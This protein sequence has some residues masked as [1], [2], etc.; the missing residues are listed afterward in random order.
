MCMKN[1]KILLILVGITFVLV[2]FYFIYY[3]KFGW[4]RAGA[5]SITLDS[6]ADWQAGTAAGIDLTTSPGD[7]RLNSANP[8]WTQATAAAGWTGRDGHTSVVFDNKMWVMGGSDG[9]TY[10]NDVWWSTDGATWTQATAAAGWTGRFFHSS[11]VFDNKMWVMGGRDTGGYKNDVW[12]SSDG[13]NWTQAT[14]DAGWSE[15]EG[16]TSVVFDNK[17]W[18]MGGYNVFLSP[19]HK[20][21]VWYSTDGATWTQATAAAGWS[22]R[23]DFPSVVYDSKMWVM[24]GYHTGPYPPGYKNDVWWSTDG[25][26]WTQATAAAGWTWRGGHTSVVYDNKMWVM[27]GQGAFNDVWWSTDGATWTQ[28]TAAG[29]A[30]RYWHTSVVYDNKMWVMGGFGTGPSFKN[31]VWYSTWRGIHTTAATQI[32]GGTS[33]TGWTT[34]VPAA[35]IPANTAISFRFR[36]SLN[37]STWTSWS[38][39]TPYAASIDISGLAVQRYLQV[40]ATLSN[41]DSVS[42][43]TIDSYTINFNNSATPTPTTPTPTP[44]TPTP[45]PPTPT[46]T[47]PTPTP[48]PPTPTPTLTPTSSDTP[49]PITPSPSNTPSLSPSTSL[50][51]SPSPSYSFPPEE[52]EIIIIRIIDHVSKKEFNVSNQRENE[53]VKIFDQRPTFIGIGKANTK[54]DLYIGSNNIHGETTSND[55]GIFTYQPSIDLDFGNHQILASQTLFDGQSHLFQTSNIV[56]FEIVKGNI[57]GGIDV[58]N[59]FVVV[60]TLLNLALLTYLNPFA[61]TSVYFYRLW[62]NILEWLGIRKKRKAWGL[63]YDYLTKKTL[64]LA[65]VRIVD[66]TNNK[67]RDTY[68]TDKDGGY[69]F[70]AESGQFI[71]KAYKNL[72]EFPV[73]QLNKQNDKIW[74]KGESDG[75]Y[76]DL[77]S[78][79][80]FSLG[81]GEEHLINCNIPMENTGRSA[82]FIRGR[83]IADFMIKALE[84]IRIPLLII[85]TALSIFTLVSY[86]DTLAILILIF[87]ILLWLLEFLRMINYYKHYGE[88]IDPEGSL[89]S[90]AVVRLIQIDNKKEKIIKIDITG[91]QG[92]YNLLVLPGE[93]YLDVKKAGYKKYR[94]ERFE[95]KSKRFLDFDIKLSK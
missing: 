39:S 48:V 47:P 18:V 92:R 41:T 6:Q 5:G 24:G 78:G 21:D 53:R 74:Q 83:R 49:I 61:N 94:S 77:Y 1:K 35:T 64:P 4:G 81:K 15:R 29:W 73:S 66:A 7:I 51:S 80:Y 85:G 13:I 54:I 91:K 58:V 67:V 20:N 36:T 71:I 32:D 14:A 44:T 9:A 57:I 26:T 59:P 2:S 3:L 95:V 70:I 45:T 34:F 75:R 86:P 46:P 56:R 43:P 16:H 63:V 11:V 30:V 38:A 10:K 27:G 76:E 19:P 68:I 17:M 40:E 50:S 55:Q 31:D 69:Y 22:E 82:V 28:A 79:G 89:I 52:L 25:A 8:V 33:L 88:V 12:Y 93:Y 42:V 84:K 23:R 65:V 72:Y 60:L 87:Y 90:Q 37:G 62:L